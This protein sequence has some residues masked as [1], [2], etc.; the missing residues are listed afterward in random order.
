MKIKRF[1]RFKD[2][3]AGVKKNVEKEGG[4]GWKTIGKIVPYITMWRQMS[5]EMFPKTHMV[6]DLYK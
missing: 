4:N 6:A 1:I 5:G 2:R 3:G